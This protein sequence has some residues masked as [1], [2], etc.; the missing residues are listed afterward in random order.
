M[1]EKVEIIHEISTYGRSAA[2]LA[3]VI[4][5]QHNRPA[6]K[7]RGLLNLLKANNDVELAALSQDRIVFNRHTHHEISWL[8]NH[9]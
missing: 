5:A 8:E 6:K 3:N 2:F 1:I 7:L 9:A 4:V